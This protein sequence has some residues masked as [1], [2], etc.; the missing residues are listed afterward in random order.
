M[1]QS[2]PV[3]DVIANVEKLC[4]EI[5]NHDSLIRARSGVLKIKCGKQGHVAGL[6]FTETF[7]KTVTTSPA[8]RFCAKLF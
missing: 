4:G 3:S 2:Q 7:K 1:G 8:N 6:Y 5:Q